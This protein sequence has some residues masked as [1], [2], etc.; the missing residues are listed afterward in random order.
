M[1]NKSLLVLSFIFGFATSAS[2]MERPRG[3]DTFRVTSRATI[4]GISFFSAEEGEYKQ[5]AEL[6][7]GKAFTEGLPGYSDEGEFNDEKLS[8]WFK[9]QNLSRQFGEKKNLF[10]TYNVM[11]PEAGDIGYIHFGRM[12]TL[13]KYDPVK[14]AAII[15][16]FMALGVTQKKD[17]A[18]GLELDNIERV[19]NRGLAHMLPI[20]KDGLEEEV[21][22]SV[23]NATFAF[24]KKMADQGF[25]LPIEETKPHQLIGLFS[26]EDPLLSLFK[27]A[28]FEVTE[29]AGFYEFYNKDRVMVHTRLGE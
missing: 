26:P 10:H 9:N 22:V 19:D 1:F 13:A 17:A 16:Q 4:Q 18:G 12:P 21:V 29:N 5:V 20:L 7:S 27:R 14:H 23:L 15:E 2:A 25:N 24:A 3:E 28:G 8:S 6:V 11:H